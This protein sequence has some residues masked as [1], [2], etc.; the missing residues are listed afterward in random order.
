VDITP[1]LAELFGI[2]TGD[3]SMSE[4]A[5]SND[6][7]SVQLCIGAS[8]DEKEWLVY[9][10]CLFQRAFNHHP[11]IYW[12]PNWNP[13][14][15]AI[16]MRVSRICDFLNEVGFPIGRKALI[17]RVPKIIV[18]AD[19][20]VQK[21]FLRGY[22]DAD[23][24]LSFERK[25]KGRAVAFKRTYH[26]YPRITLASI[27]KGLISTDIKQML[28]NVDT[29]YNIRKR[30]L[31]EKEKHESYLAVVNGAIQ[32][33]SWM[34]KIGSSNP[35]HITKYNV[36]KRFGFCPPK[37]TLNQRLAMLTGKLDPKI[38]YKNM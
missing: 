19:E 12:N 20:D 3:G 14:K 4:S 27:S 11:K 6:R 31:G 16:F 13:N 28:E 32:L 21:A 26:Y 10:A 25:L 5:V 2:Y 17:A 24:C 7:K 29:R 30:K 9:V 22:F 37:T 38:F 18:D 23:G 34:R 8:K 36:W 33:E 1:E 15:Y 35:V